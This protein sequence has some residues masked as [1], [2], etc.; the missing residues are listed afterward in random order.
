MGRPPSPRI[1]GQEGVLRG[2]GIQQPLYPLQSKRP[3][4]KAELAGH[5]STIVIPC[6][7]AHA[8]NY[9]LC[10][11]PDGLTASLDGLHL[12]SLQGPLQG[13]GRVGMDVYLATDG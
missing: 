4:E 12:G 6:R 8:Q 9:T 13:G 7:D 2:K 3:T 11:G 5:R 1:P 10:S